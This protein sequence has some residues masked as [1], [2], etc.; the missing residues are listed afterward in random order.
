MS[1]RK[2]VG[3]LGSGVVGQTLAGGFVKHGFETMIGSRE[4][5]K[6][7]EW[8]KKAGP[9][10]KAGS[11]EEATRFGEIVV[12]AVKGTVAEEVVRKAGA[13]ALAGKVVI[14]ATNP[15]AD[16]APAAGVLTL[17][18][19]P[20]ESLMERLQRS[21]PEA[22]FV[23]AFNS[24]GNALMINPKLRGGP[25]TMFICG[26]DGEARKEVAEILTLFGWDTEDMGTAESARAIEPLCVHWCIP[27]FL[28]NDWMHAFKMLRP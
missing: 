20:G 5:E 15:I 24:V 3:V 26:N 6:L 27:G 19:K 4:P 22:R 16:A 10:A 11:V 13:Q 8:A 9:L 18:T 25:P 7:A 1:S 21:A 28:K 23:K 14:D 12:L 2:Q 17:F